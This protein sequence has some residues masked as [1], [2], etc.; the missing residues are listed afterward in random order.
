MHPHLRVQAHFTIALQVPEPSFPGRVDVPPRPV[1]P[2]HHPAQPGPCRRF[3]GVGFES[4]QP[5]WAARP[6]MARASAPGGDLA[7]RA[8]RWLRRPA[9]V[10]SI[11][12]R[13]ASMSI[14]R[15]RV[16]FDPPPAA[17]TPQPGGAPEITTPSRG[18]I[19]PLGRRRRL[20]EGGGIPPAGALL[21]AAPLLPNSSETAHAVHGAARAACAALHVSRAQ[22][23]P[24]MPALRRADSGQQRARIR[25]G[26]RQRKRAA[27][28]GTIG[29][30]GRR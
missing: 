19:D 11:P 17:A 16:R 26:R 18:S 7:V 21:R 23:G 9:V 27:Q 12:T 29:E 28:R 3:G 15:R 4:A 10:G 30:S 24:P 13:A 20:G 14:A 25:H 2:R 6:L 5:T 8:A 22:R 1:G